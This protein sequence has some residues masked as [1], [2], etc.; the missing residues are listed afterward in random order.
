[1]ADE[2]G[3]RKDAVRRHLAGESAGDIAA[4][5]ERTERWV[6]KWV[7][8]YEESGPQWFEARSRGPK[9]RPRATPDETVALVLAAR[10]RLE[11]DPRA[12]R[13]A[14][15]IAWQ[16]VCMDVPRS[17]LPSLRTIELI[18][19]RYGRAKP[20]RAR[21]DRYQPKGVPYPFG[22]EGV[23]V[24][25][26]H[27]IDAV[28]PRY[29][30]GGQEVHSLNVMDVGSHRAALEP[31]VYPTPAAF[32]HH[33]LRAWGR[34]GLP[35]VAQLDNHPSMRGDIKRGRV[36]GPVVRLCLALGVRVRF[37]PIKEP[38]RN[39][40]I[41]H[42]QDVFDKSFFRT[43]RFT[44]PTH[45]KRRSR[46]FER[47]HNAEHRYS[48]LKGRTPDEALTASGVLVAM[49][50]AS[51]DIPERL[52]RRGHIEAVRFIRSDRI[53][54]LF[55]EKILLPERVVHQYVVATIQVRARRLVVTTCTGEIVHESDHPV[56]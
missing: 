14:V 23:G 16:L 36:F 6:Y 12:Q 52:P 55:G 10:D 27:Q 46:V 34:L 26:L 7:A 40:V 13:G 54:N 39:G 22:S 11:S 25:V 41:E 32:S 48:V 2:E 47:F 44:D 9:R 8:R 18:I 49:P 56:V 28:G 51:L 21:K 45:L 43:E 29:L 4:D 50:P 37:I 17:K 19:A 42:F 24:G 53:L 5:L 15:A 1:M 31:L 33:L 20:R 35:S 38:W 30:D 3:L